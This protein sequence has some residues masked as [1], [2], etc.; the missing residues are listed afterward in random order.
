MSHQISVREW[1]MRLDPDRMPVSYQGRSIE[2]VSIRLPSGA[3]R[4]EAWLVFGTDDEL[5]VPIETRLDITP[6]GAP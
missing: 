1:L 5:P 4:D 3:Y 6:G 2:A